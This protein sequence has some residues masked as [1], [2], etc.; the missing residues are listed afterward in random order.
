MNKNSMQLYKLFG[1][2]VKAKLNYHLNS[3]W[4]MNFTK[5]ELT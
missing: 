2:I 5:Y 4:H 3:I 1:T